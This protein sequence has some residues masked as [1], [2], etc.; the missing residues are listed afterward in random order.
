[1]R[2]RAEQGLG[3]PLG[4]RRAEGSL[5]LLMQVQGAMQREG[6]LA[7]GRTCLKWALWRGR[8]A[9]RERCRSLLGLREQGAVRA[10]EPEK[11]QR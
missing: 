2:E 1:M 7:Q 6:A 5:Q 11:Q 9:V 4:R 8:E 3:G 10:E